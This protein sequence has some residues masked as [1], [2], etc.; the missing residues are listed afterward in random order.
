MR[1]KTQERFEQLLATAM[2]ARTVWNRAKVDSYASTEHVA[3]CHEQYWN[4]YNELM[5]FTV[6]M[7]RCRE[8]VRMVFAGK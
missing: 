2:D 4:A 3:H 5:D 7:P 1:Q 6:R 8:I